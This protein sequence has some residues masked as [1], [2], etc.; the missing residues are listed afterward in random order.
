MSRQMLISIGILLLVFGSGVG[1]GLFLGG[2]TSVANAVDKG[3]SNTFAGFSRA[4][5]W[6]GT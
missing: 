2:G 1:V 6:A 4:L 3:A 5:L